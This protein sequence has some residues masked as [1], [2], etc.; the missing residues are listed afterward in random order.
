MTKQETKQ[1]EVKE[2]Q[3][4][5]SITLEQAGHQLQL[6]QHNIK[7]MQTQYN[8]L[9]KHWFEGVKAAEEAANKTKE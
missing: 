7:N 3:A 1:T 4:K 2:E 5:P 9:Y 8:E 6:M